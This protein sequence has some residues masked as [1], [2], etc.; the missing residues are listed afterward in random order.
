MPD[1]ADNQ[2]DQL[3]WRHRGLPESAMGLSVHEYLERSESLFTDG[4]QWPQAIILES[5]LE[6]NL[7]TMKVFCERHNVALAPH[8]KTHMSPQLAARQI[9]SGAWGITVANASQARTFLELGFRKIVIANEVVN[10]SSLK[11][12]S[13]QDAEI[14]FYIDSLA[15]FDI[16]EENVSGPVNILVEVGKKRGR[17]GVRSL[18]DGHELAK[19]IH[20]A[21]N[22]RLAGVSGYEGVFGKDRSR[23]SVR[24]VR[25]FLKSLV[26]FAQALS[27]YGESPFWVSAGGSAYFD[28]VVD[29]LRPLTRSQDYTVVI[30]SGGYL[31]HD[32]GFYEGIYPFVKDPEFS[33]VP[34]IEVWSMVTSKPEKNLVIIN[35][36]KRDISV[37]IDLPFPLKFKSGDGDIKPLEGTVVNVNDQHIYLTTTNQELKVGD[38]VALGISHPCT[39]FDKWPLIALTDDGYRILS[40]Y[41]TYF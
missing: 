29:E 21:P 27:V 15:G 5:A 24:K 35:G 19:K 12:L 2:K 31:A 17:T 22:M 28:L 41:S 8:V 38:L 25:D 18:K 9:D 20:D 1:F 33:F 30:R 26:E 13:E 11:Y 16:V 32:H 10:P 36:G 34:A 39:T 3:S 6:H 23:A 7:T 37:D 14:Y 4:F 40:L